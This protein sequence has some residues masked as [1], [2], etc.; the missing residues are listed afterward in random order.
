MA[1]VKWR[2]PAGSISPLDG[3]TL[4]TSNTG[5]LCP[6]CG[7]DTNAGT[8]LAPVKSWGAAA[9]IGKTYVVPNGYIFNQ[10]V[11]TAFKIIGDGFVYFQSNI[12]PR[13][14]MLVYANAQIYGCMASGYSKIADWFNTTA[15]G[16]M[17]YNKFKAVNPANFG[18]QT[19][20]GANARQF[21]VLICESGTPS[22]HNVGASVVKNNSFI[23]APSAI[24]NG[25]LL[26]GTISVNNIYAGQGSYDIPDIDSAKN[27]FRAYIVNTL[28]IKMR[29]GTG[30]NETTFTAVASIAALRIRA[31]AVYGGVVADYFP[32]SYVGPNPF[33]ATGSELYEV[34]GDHRL[35]IAAGAGLTAASMADNNAHVGAYQ[36]GIRWDAGPTD[37][38][39]VSNLTLDSGKYKLTNT[40]LPG[41]AISKIKTFGKNRDIK[42]NSFMGVDAYLNGIVLDASRD[43]SAWIFSTFDGVN[44]VFTGLNAPG[45]Y[46]VN[47]ADGFVT[48]NGQN[49][50]LGDKI[51]TVPGI[52]TAIDSDGNSRL[53]EILERPN[54][55]SLLWR[56]SQGGSIT[57][58]VT[59]YP[60]NAWLYVVSGTVTQG[61]NNY[62][63]ESFLLFNSGLTYSGTYSVQFVYLDNEPYLEMEISTSKP[64]S[65]NATVGNASQSFNYGAETLISCKF[66]QHMVVIQFDNIR[67]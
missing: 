34:W 41:S 28:L 51:T 44:N 64:V 15:V 58:A 10:Q 11:T 35:N 6:Q 60:N 21:S 33:M 56:F 26:G 53:K 9:L 55:K 38:L 27:V 14:P 37:Y 17:Q 25:T 39:S 52:T 13:I 4:T 61:T 57:N 32:D 67:Y 20:V 49:Y 47:V 1:A 30:V 18:F 63:A 8:D 16:G 31:V 62:P 42:R 29:G 43:S 23:I 22:L 46:E 5:W 54:K 50:F 40:A 3:V 24:C 19:P 59:N 65:K 36:S 12:Q 2:Y 7:K 45:G 66:L 48:Y